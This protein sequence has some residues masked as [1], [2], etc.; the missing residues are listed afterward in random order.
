MVRH[1]LKR[2]ASILTIIAIVCTTL[3]TGRMNLIEVSAEGASSTNGSMFAGGSGTPEDPWLISTAD[4]LDEVRNHWDRN[5]KLINDIDLSEYGNWE[6]IPVFGGSLD[7]NNY[8]IQ[9]LYVRERSGGLFD[10]IESYA[11]VARVNLEVDIDGS[12]NSGGFANRLLGEISESSVTGSIKGNFYTGAIASIMESN[13]RL[14]DS[15]SVADVQGKGIYSNATGGLVGIAQSSVTIEGSH[16]SGSVSGFGTVGGLTGQGGGHISNSY[17]D[18]D[19]YAARDSSGARV[20]GLVGWSYYY[21]DA[22]ISDSYFLG[23]IKS[24]GIAGG[25][26]GINDGG[27]DTNWIRRSYSKGTIT[28]DNFYSIVGGLIGET[29]GTFTIDESFSSGVISGKFNYVGGLIGQSRQAKITNSYS[30]AKISGQE[31]VGGLVGMNIIAQDGFIKNSFSAAEISGTRRVGSILGS[32]FEGSSDGNLEFE[33]IYWDM[34]RTNTSSQYGGLGVSTESMKQQSTYDNWDF[35]TIWGIDENVSYPFLRS[36]GA[37][38]QD[39]IDPFV[40]S[41]EISLEDRQNLILT[42]NEIVNISSLDG[43]IIKRNGQ[44]VQPTE[45]EKLS[46]MEWAIR[47]PYPILF[48]D[49]VTFTYQSEAGIIV[50]LGKNALLSVDDLPVVN[51]R[52][53]YLG[54][55]TQ[56]SPWKIATPAQLSGIRYLDVT[57]QKY[58]TL[59]ANIDLTPYVQ[60]GGAGYNNGEGWLPIKQFNGHFDGA[61]HTIKGLYIRGEQGGLFERV[62]EAGIVQNLGFINTDIE[63]TGTAGAIASVVLGR[64]ENSYVTGTIKGGNDVGGLVGKL[65][66][67]VIHNSYSKAQVVGNENVGGLAGNAAENSVVSSSFSDNTVSGAHA[68]GGLLGVVEASEVMDSYSISSV[69]GD[70]RTGGLIGWL[71]SD[72]LVRSSYSAGIVDDSS[73]LGGLIGGRADTQN[74]IVERSYWDTM[75]TRQTSFEGGVGHETTQMKQLRTYAEWDFNKAWAIDEGATYPYLQGIGKNEQPD[76]AAPTLVDAY[77]GPLDRSKLTMVVDEPISPLYWIPD[78]QLLTGQGIILEPDSVYNVDNKTVEFILNRPVNIDDTVKFSVADARF[79]KD[80]SGN[81]IASY[82]DRTIENRLLDHFFGDGSG[83][84]ED[85]LQIATPEHLDHIRAYG[86]TTGT[87]FELTADIDLTDYLSEAGAG[88]DPN[89]WLPIPMFNGTLNGAGFSIKGIKMSNRNGGLFHT[90]SDQALVKNLTLHNVLLDRAYD[91]GAMAAYTKGI[92]TDSSVSGSIT[93][94]DSG[95]LLGGLTGQLLGNGQIKNSESN[96]QISGI[97]RLGGL[98]GDVRDNGKIINSSSEG[99]VEGTTYLG[100]LAGLVAGSARIGI[101]NSHSTASVKGESEIG[102]LVGVLEA[103]DIL[104]SSSTGD[105]TG[106]VDYIGG[107]VGVGDGCLI[108]DSFYEGTVSGNQ[109]IG[110]IGGYL[111]HGCEIDNS[112]SKGQIIGNTM[113][114]GLI[115]NAYRD[116][117]VVDSFSEAAVEGQAQLGGLIGSF[118]R[119]LIRN[120]YMNGSVNGSSKLGGLIGTMQDGQIIGSY[121]EG[122]ITGVSDLGGL[123]GAGYGMIEDSYSSTSLT[124]KENVGGL[125]GQYTWGTIERSYSEGRI[126]GESNIGGLI[127]YGPNIALKINDSYSI[128]NVSGDNHV[129]GLAGY[130]EGTVAN[131]Y[132]LATVPGGAHTGIIIGRRDTQGTPSI[133]NSYWNEDQTL[134]GSIYGGQG[135]GTAALK[136]QSTFKNWNFDSVWMITDG[137]AYPYLRHVDLEKQNDIAPPTVIAAKIPVI[138]RD[139][140]IVTFDE[141]AYQVDEKGF[142]LMDNGSPIIVTSLVDHNE[143]RTEWTFELEQSVSIPET[144]SNTLKLSYEAADGSIADDAGNIMTSFTDKSITDQW[145][146]Q[147]FAGGSGSLE[148]P[149][150][151]LFPKHVSNIRNYQDQ[152]DAHFKLAANIDFSDYIDSGE[153]GADGWQPI[154]SFRGHL[155]GAGFQISGLSGKYGLFDT[156]EEGAVIANLGLVDVNLQSNQSV[157]AFATTLYGT[158]QDSFVSGSI[159]VSSEF[160]SVGGLAADVKGSGLIQGSYNNAKVQG[161]RDAGGLAGTI[162]DE[163]IISSSYNAGDIISSSIAGGLAGSITGLPRTA[164]TDSYNIASV[165]SSSYTGGLV[166]GLYDASIRNS[167]NSG[168]ITGTS[169]VGGIA[170]YSMN[171]CVVNGSYNDGSV[172]GQLTSVGGLAGASYTCTFEQSYNSGTVTGD[173]QVGG[174][175]GMAAGVEGVKLINTYNTAT[176][177]GRGSVGGLVGV[178]FGGV[179]RN[180][181]A[182]SE[183]IGIASYIGGLIGEGRV[184]NKP[185]VESSYWNLDLFEDTNEYGGIGKSTKELKQQ[186]M[187]TDWDFNKVWNIHDGRAYPFLQGEQF[188]EPMDTVEPYVIKAEIRSDKPDQLLVTFDEE[189]Q[190]TMEGF[191]VVV[192]GEAILVLDAAVTNEATTWSIQLE[193]L[194]STDAQVTLTYDAAIGHAA[195]L[196]GN[197]LSHFTD[198]PVTISVISN[199]ATVTVGSD[200]YDVIEADKTII[201]NQTDIT[202]ETTVVELLNELTK[203]EKAE[204]KVVD[205]DTSITS[206]EQFEAATEKQETDQLVSGDKL[207]V[208]AEDGTIAVY[209][210][211]VK[212][213]INVY[214]EANGGTSINSQVIV[215]GKYAVTPS[216]PIRA[217]Y[218]FAGWFLD[219]GVFEQSIDLAST[220]ITSDTIIYAKWVI[221]QELVVTITSVHSIVTGNEAS[222]PYGESVQLTA[223]PEEGYQFESWKDAATGKVL[224]TQ[225]NYSFNITEGIRLIATSSKIEEEVFTVRF[226]NESGYVLSI[227]Q[228]PSGGDA[229]PPLNPSKPDAE[230]IGWSSDYT[231]VQQDITL[232]PIYSEKVKRYTL[233][234]HGGSIPSG[235]TS[236]LFDSKAT[237]ETNEPAEGSQFSHWENNHKIVSYNEIYTFYITGDTTLTAVYKSVPVVKA[238]IVTI[239]PDVIA[240]PLTLRM[241]F[242][243]QFDIASPFVFV[244]TGV[245][246][247]KSETPITELHFG[248]ANAIKARSSTQTE[249]GQFMMNKTGVQSGETWYAVTYLIYKDASGEVYTIYS[250]IVSG[251][252]P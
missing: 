29:L 52:E 37:S 159:I 10:T 204:W 120:S 189:V 196:A 245:V 41:A 218:R 233:T 62:G 200:A 25:L 23:N 216:N 140:L 168:A 123:V 12:Q 112:Y 135:M 73:S 94:D 173:T 212:S 202:V 68:A 88:F 98:A 113:A 138:E 158:I 142:S 137:A 129:G 182:N 252:M 86:D 95:Y 119:S 93:N 234:V 87:Y 145:L 240:N 176:V 21:R 4:Q 56:E 20:G 249:T 60:S 80:L 141:P 248:T 201:S 16:S 211:I 79:F 24:D 208:M 92:I 78:M 103:V 111:Q 97:S 199:D 225:L 70:E 150:L 188:I 162:E 209:G 161:G 195:D 238:P 116:I 13:A 164:I 75:R 171:G 11:S 65:E 2:W 153:A 167:Y 45:A 185:A 191:T 82:E 198:W 215:S 58:Y 64:I 36:I 172:T 187:F 146:E 206:T 76:Q 210:I 110:G 121:T 105:V 134:I 102:G 81:V 181:L 251:T 184:A 219:D 114:G 147:D 14:I 226:M 5:F 228:V 220:P 43:I 144:T 223:V 32:H 46:G 186:A 193:E 39:W 177:T 26:I 217:G 90:L 117:I 213:M 63:A 19:I 180:S 157:G 6:P 108:Q 227:Q 244:E 53:N 133:S 166:G 84:S 9:G 55:G 35:N 18:A 242:I 165:N 101:E 66:N 124:G 50:D 85:P 214:F 232:K 44:E 194:V 99:S 143:Y 237:V 54:N 136:Q 156:V 72:S 179:I 130:Y 91:S 71:G 31:Y 100:G 178:M 221:E 42:F 38:A 96:V 190:L 22:Y 30:T 61:G 109:Y 154:R 104:G 241:S 74:S 243:G 170:G 7:G 247:K 148:D 48:N 33:N 149:W 207:V 132:S 59:V 246:V 250:D 83:T 57:D 222:Y 51:Q 126:A 106:T 131:S 122:S 169:F 69:T 27:P 115:G 205:I 160:V 183:V 163:G 40:V 1:R 47:L 235:A 125:F 15:H 203:H 128:A 34:D 175:V 174:L 230:F 49:T 197:Q 127:G 67:A 231:N 118:E 8:V 139:K 236:Y 152:K 89:G 239:S 3:L 17:S 28:G 107:L 192:D 229:T 77:I 151:I 224:S 155:D